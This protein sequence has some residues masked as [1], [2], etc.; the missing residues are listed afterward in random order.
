MTREI[1]MIQSDIIAN[2]LVMVLDNMVLYI[3]LGLDLGIRKSKSVHSKIEC[4]DNNENK[5]VP[6]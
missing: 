2:Q 5:I 6:P 3:C 4:I 1:I